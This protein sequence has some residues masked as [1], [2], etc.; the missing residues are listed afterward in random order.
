MK[1]LLFYTT[2][3]RHKIATA[4]Y[5]AARTISTVLSMEKDWQIHVPGKMYWLKNVPFYSHSFQNME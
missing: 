5:P 1:A 2:E 4:K 3:I